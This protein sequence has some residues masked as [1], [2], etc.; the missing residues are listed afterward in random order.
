MSDNDIEQISLYLSQIASSLQV[1]SGSMMML[2]SHLMTI[3]NELTSIY[4]TRNTTQSYIAELSLISEAVHRQTRP[5]VIYK[6][7]LSSDGE[8]WVVVYGNAYKGLMGYGD[9]PELAMK[10]FDD[11]W[12]GK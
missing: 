5:S 6:P 9:T 11:K 4:S 3:N 2:E 12:A 8:S 1:M 7:D 10:D